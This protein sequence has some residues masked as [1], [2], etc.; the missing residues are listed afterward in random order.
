MIDN[1]SKNG[2]NALHTLVDEPDTEELPSLPPEPADQI[3]APPRMLTPAEAIEAS[4]AQVVGV[5]VRG[6][7]VSCSGV[8]A[9]FVL[10]KIA[11]ACGKLLAVS[12]QG[13]PLEATVKAR[14]DFKKAFEDGMAKVSVLQMGGAMQPQPGPNLRR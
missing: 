8:P 12:I 2:A 13:N 1:D 5:T 9:G 6:L 3:A 4:I 14:S 11:F 7:M 10:Q